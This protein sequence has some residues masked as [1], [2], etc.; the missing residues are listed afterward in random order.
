MVFISI[1]NLLQV[2]ILDVIYARFAG[3]TRQR[4]VV[5]QPTVR[6]LGWLCLCRRR[7]MRRVLGLGSAG[8]PGVLVR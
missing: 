5:N 8:Y 1:V 2:C 4:V 6:D 7:F 3:H